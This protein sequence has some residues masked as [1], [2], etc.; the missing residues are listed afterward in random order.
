MKRWFTIIILLAAACGR[1]GDA[2]TPEAVDE[3]AHARGVIVLTP[4][5]EASAQLATAKAEARTTTGLLQAT[6]EVEPSG[7]GVARVGPR[8]GGRI[9]SL[10]VGIGDAVKKGQTL[11][12][13][14]APELSRAKAD[15]LSAAASWKVAREKAD[16][17]KA[18]YD[19]KISSEADWRDAEAE[20][21]RARA[22]MQAG[23]SLLRSMGVGDA[24]IGK[25]DLDRKQT[26]G[27]SLTAP[28]EGVVVERNATLGE[29][30]EPSDALFVIMDLR[31]VWVQVDV[32]ERDL[33]QAKVGQ[34]VTAHV[35]AYPGRAFPGSVAA[36]GAVVEPKTRA[37]QV[38]VVLPN[39]DG[40]LKPGMF[41]TVELEGTSGVAH[42][43]V[44]VPS[45]AVQRDG[46]RSVVFVKTGEHE[47]AQHIVKLGLE[48]AGSVEIEEG[49]AAGDEV[50][51]TGSF[52]LKSELRKGEMGED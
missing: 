28:I 26:S 4:E 35:T 34:K 32:F 30:A 15:Y 49:V 47:Y 43:R 24:Q 48:T 44:V 45:T 25:L 50:I 19:K 40:A 9:L 27:I 52:V 22:D 14:D 1:D 5:Q 42:Q 2:K 33:A 41:A 21:A 10:S 46:D 13:L 18:L 51:T 29:M 6:A 11:A 31:Q 3:E 16:R 12:T 20:A 39:D 37:V 17:E 23:A 8:L 7:D 38:R 36:I